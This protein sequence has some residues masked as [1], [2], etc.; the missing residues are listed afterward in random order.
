[1]ERPASQLTMKLMKRPNQPPRH[2]LKAL[3]MS[4]ALMLPTG[5]TIADEPAVQQVM[6]WIP[7][8]GTAATKEARV[9]QITERRSGVL[10]SRRLIEPPAGHRVVVT[11]STNGYAGTF[12]TQLV[13]DET[14]WWVELETDF[15]FE[16]ENL[17]EFLNLVGDRINEPEATLHLTLRTSENVRHEAEVSVAG[18]IHLAAEA[19]GRG[20]ASTPTGQALAESIP[21]GLVPTLAFLN[22]HTTA[23]YIEGILTLTR[24]LAALEPAV[25]DPATSPG[26]WRFEAEE[27]N[28]GFTVTDPELRSFMERFS[29]VDPDRPMEPIP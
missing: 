1:M 21:P 11:L 16:T 20:L 17:K 14:G 22:Q 6:Q 15:G 2:V 4:A 7:V 26:R 29:T 28:K 25:A 24:L 19:F 13:D 23:T 9:L 5:A 8:E 10:M 27:S 3:A 12:L 18:Q